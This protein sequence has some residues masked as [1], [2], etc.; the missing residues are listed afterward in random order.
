VHGLGT[1]PPE[2]P[3]GRVGRRA[4]RVDVVHERDHARRGSARD[5]C[6]L[7]VGPPLGAGEPALPRNRPG[8]PQQPR[9]GQLPPAAEVTRERLGRGDS[10]PSASVRVRR[11]E[12]EG[13]C[14]RRG[15]D[16]RDE[17]AGNAGEATAARAEAKERR[18]P[19][20]SPQR[21]TGQA[22][23]APQRPQSVPPRRRRPARQARQR[24]PSSPAPQARQRS[25]KRRSMM[26]A[27]V[28]A[29]I[30][31]WGG[32]AAPRACVAHG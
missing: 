3:C 28:R 13:A 31:S 16:L 1:R 20:H 5:E 9:D 21:S 10:A 2:R 7:D 19:A 25:G 32:I 29:P 26:A 17:S 23:G 12:G 24:R 11:D 14:G 30:P 4:G 18:R 27:P 6:V 22:V 8:S 15:H